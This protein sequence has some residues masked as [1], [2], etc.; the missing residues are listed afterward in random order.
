MDCLEFELDTSIYFPLRSTPHP[1]LEQLE[2]TGQN[3]KEPEE[4]D[5]K[6]SD[7]KIIKNSG[8]PDENVISNRTCSRFTQTEKTDES[9]MA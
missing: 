2:P 5:L 6:D 3:E 4:W 7:I 1:H 9:I 8:K